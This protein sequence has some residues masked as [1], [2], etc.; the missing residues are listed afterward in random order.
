MAAAFWG[1]GPALMRAGVENNGLGVLG[2][3]VAYASASIVLV[4]TLALP[5]QA[6]GA[7]KLDPNARGLFLV[8]GLTSWGANILRFSA[9]AL[10]PVSVVVPVMRSSILFTL[11]MNYFFNRHL[12]SFEPKLLIAIGISMIGAI[13]LVL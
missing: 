13:L 3:T 7:L 12:E 2:G 8:G 6:E 11:G 4:A 9:L 10:A 5:G 1:A